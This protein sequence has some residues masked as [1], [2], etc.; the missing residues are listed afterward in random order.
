M[1]EIEFQTCD[2]GDQPDGAN[3]DRRPAAEHSEREGYRLCCDKESASEQ[4][5]K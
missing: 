2:P 5:K 1:E 4:D 3:H